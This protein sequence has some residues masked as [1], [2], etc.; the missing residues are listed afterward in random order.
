MLFTQLLASDILGSPHLT[1]SEK[2]K[3][4]TDDIE[5]T[6]VEIK[7]TIE[8]TPMPPL[9]LRIE[10]GR[11]IENDVFDAREIHDPFDHTMCDRLVTVIYYGCNFV[12][13]IWRIGITTPFVL[14]TILCCTPTAVAIAGIGFI[15]GIFCAITYVAKGD[16]T[17]CGLFTVCKKLGTVTEKIYKY[18]SKPIPH[19]WE[20]S[21]IKKFWPHRRNYVA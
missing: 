11:H 17:S 18:T 6:E 16:A 13:Y 8:V 10:L 7:T 9:A 12:D 1:S 3:F 20:L 14:F 5:N 21:F 2:A 15:G 19:V 4:E